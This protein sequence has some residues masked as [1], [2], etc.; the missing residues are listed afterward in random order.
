M[1]SG[2]P[3]VKGGRYNELLKHFGKPAASIGFV[4]V[5]DSLLMA[6]SRQK[7]KVMEDEAPLILTYTEKNRREAILEAQRL[8]KEGTC[9]ALRCEK[10]ED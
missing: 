3:V 1:G 9:V 10:E 4:I 8:R 6:L 5:V 7:I 2:E